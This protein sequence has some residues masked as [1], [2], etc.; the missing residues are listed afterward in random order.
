MNSTGAAH[1][2]GGKAV[3]EL[4]II[5]GM[6]ESIDV[7]SR[8]DG[9][10]QRVVGNLISAGTVRAGGIIAAVLIHEMNYAHAMRRR[11][12]PRR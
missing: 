1:A 2:V 4:V 11:W 6:A 8:M 12:R 3:V 9:H 7:S 10:E 5:P